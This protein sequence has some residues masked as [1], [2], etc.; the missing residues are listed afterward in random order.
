MPII[1]FKAKDIF[2][3]YLDKQNCFKKIINS[4]LQRAYTGN[5]I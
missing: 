4:K 5:K 1:L 2:H 3:I